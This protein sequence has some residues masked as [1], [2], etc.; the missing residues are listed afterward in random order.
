MLRGV[1]PASP[2]LLVG[3]EFEWLQRGIIDHKGTMN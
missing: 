3:L 1:L 2:A